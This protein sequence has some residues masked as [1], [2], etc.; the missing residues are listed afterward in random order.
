[1]WCW[2]KKAR[3]GCVP[4]LAQRAVSEDPRWG[5]GASRR[6]VR[7]V[8]EMS[9]AVETHP[10][11]LPFGGDGNRM[12]STPRCSLNA[13]P[14]K[15][16][17]Q[18]A[19]EKHASHPVQKGWAN[20][21]GI[22]VIRSTVGLS[23]AAVL[24]TGMGCALFRSAPEGT[25]KRATAEE[26]TVLLRQREAAIHSMKGLFSAKVRGGFI[27]IA[28]RVEGAVYYRR[29]NALRLRGFTSIGSEL[30]E[31]VQA[32]DVYK[33]RLPT[34]GRVLMGHQSEMA[35]MGKLA[36]PFQLSVWAVGGVLGTGTIAKGE[37]VKLADEGDRY[38]LDVYASVNGSAGQPV[39][40]RRLWFDRRTLL[41]VQE[42]RLTETGEVDATIQYEDFRPIGEPGDRPLPVKASAQLLRPFKISLEDGRGQGSVQ[43]TFH[44]MLTNQAIK[45]EDLGQVS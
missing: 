44:E 4:V 38:R 35:E 39:L 14:Q 6:V 12:R 30:F 45:T 42:D 18:C 5:N 26:L 33:L 36:R 1:M 43:V 19:H 37:T 17:I 15:G 40:A 20:G 8:G 27:P 41:V 13:R 34:I 16:F 32:D 31:F 11:L 7:W 25:F 9:R 3:E 24:L 2:R 21:I 29:P 28:S 10:S 23:L 22:G